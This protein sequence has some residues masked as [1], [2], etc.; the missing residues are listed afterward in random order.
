MQASMESRFKIRKVLQ[1]PKQGSVL[2]PV[3]IKSFEF[4]LGIF[5]GAKMIVHYFV[6]SLVVQVGKVYANN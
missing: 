2:K 1:I 5:L 6:V 4:H 3:N